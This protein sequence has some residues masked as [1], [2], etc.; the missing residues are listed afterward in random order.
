MPRRNSERLIHKEM[1]NLQLEKADWYSCGQTIITKRS[2]SKNQFIEVFILL[3]KI[4]C[5]LFMADC[6]TLADYII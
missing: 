3:Y 6:D 5:I 2:P 1:I 4:R